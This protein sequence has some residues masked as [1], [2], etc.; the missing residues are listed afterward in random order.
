[1]KAYQ[2]LGSNKRRPPAVEHDVAAQCMADHLRSLVEPGCFFSMSAEHVE[3]AL[4]PLVQPRLQQAVLQA[5]LPRDSEGRVF[6]RIVIAG[7]GF[8][9]IFG[10]RMLRASVQACDGC[11]DEAVKGAKA[12][13]GWRG[14]ALQL[15]M[16][17]GV[18]RRS[19]HG[20]W[21]VRGPTHPILGM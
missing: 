13:K 4:Q 6:L 20:L 9:H 10:Q 2:L 19:L 1:M 15:P 8:P 5:P 16:M 21:C 7:I 11:D 3:P 12:P 14:M 18:E 17:A